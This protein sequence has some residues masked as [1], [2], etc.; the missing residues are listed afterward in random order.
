MS[1]YINIINKN[2][3][4]KH[5]HATNSIRNTKANVNNAIQF[6]GNSLL[7]FTAVINTFFKKSCMTLTL[8]VQTSQF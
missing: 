7:E 5:I 6:L 4:L 1:L 3:K 2:G 8:V